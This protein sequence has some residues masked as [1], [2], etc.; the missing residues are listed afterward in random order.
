M[1]VEIVA[2]FTNVGDPLESPSNLP[3]IRIRRI[4]TQA[5]VVTDEEM[6]EIGDGN[7]SYSFTPDASLEYTIQADGDPTGVGQTTAAERYN[8]GSLS[9]IEENASVWDEDVADHDTA[10]TFGEFVQNKLLTVAKFLAL[11]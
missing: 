2:H 11:K 9:G 5:L 8:F 4:D 1:A 6:T 7:Y 3:Q 10:G